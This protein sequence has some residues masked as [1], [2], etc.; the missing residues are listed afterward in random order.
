[1]IITTSDLNMYGERMMCS[2]SFALLLKHTVPNKKQRDNKAIS[3]RGCCLFVDKAVVC[4]RDVDVLLSS[5]KRRSLQRRCDTCSI[6]IF[7]AG[8]TSCFLIVL[9]KGTYPVRFQPKFS[10]QF[11]GCCVQFQVIR[12]AAPFRSRTRLVVLSAGTIDG[13][14]AVT[15]K[16]RVGAFQKIPACSQFLPPCHLCTTPVPIWFIF[17]INVALI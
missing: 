6:T 1:M 11:C 5:E 7:F 16:V 12:F 13:I 8:W 10:R 2:D 9:D 4:R 3:R 14:D 15:K 17:H